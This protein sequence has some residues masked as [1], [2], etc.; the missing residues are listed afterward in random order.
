MPKLNFIAIKI[1]D[2][3]LFGDSS[4]KECLPV[5][6]ELQFYKDVVFD[7]IVRKHKTKSKTAYLN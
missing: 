1:K 4:Q 7:Y 2:N 3:F 6:K 5:L